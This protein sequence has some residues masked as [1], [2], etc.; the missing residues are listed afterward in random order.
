MMLK[1]DGSKCTTLEEN[2]EVFHH[3]H[4]EKLYNRNSDFDMSVLNLLEQ[5]LTDHSTCVEPSKGEICAAILHLKN[6]AQVK[7]V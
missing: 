6:K 4:F 7:Q 1:E 2:A 5:L 3:R